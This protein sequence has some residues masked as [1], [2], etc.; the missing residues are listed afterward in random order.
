M[1]ISVFETIMFVL[2]I[3]YIVISAWTINKLFKSKNSDLTK[4]GFI[5]LII[6]L[7]IIGLLSTLF[8]LNKNNKMMF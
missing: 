5:L 1:S 7:P 8:F 4:F 2:F 3:V 6:F